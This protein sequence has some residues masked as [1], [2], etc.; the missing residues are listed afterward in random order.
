MRFFYDWKTKLFF[1]CIPDVECNYIYI[2]HTLFAFN[3]RLTTFPSFFW[4]LPPCHD[5]ENVHFS[6]FSDFATEFAFQAIYFRAWTEAFLHHSGLQNFLV[7][8]NVTVTS[9]LIDFCVLR[10]V[11]SE[12]HSD[13]AYE[14][15]LKICTNYGKF[16]EIEWNA[17][18]RIKNSRGG[19]SSFKYIHEW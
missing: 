6:L 14:N 8:M 5:D 16:I 15:I 18:M 4:P 9:H 10:R 12:C 2:I 11:R 3:L 19:E 17:I 1:F 7:L 13:K